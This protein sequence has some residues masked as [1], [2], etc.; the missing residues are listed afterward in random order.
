MNPQETYAMV[1]SEIP[2]KFAAGIHNIH[3]LS[4]GSQILNNEF[5]E[6][7][8]ILVLQVEAMSHLLTIT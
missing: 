3:A 1:I 6:T 7:S 8:S 5:M 4:C 2:F